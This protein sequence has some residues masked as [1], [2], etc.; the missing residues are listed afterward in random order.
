MMPSAWHAGRSM[1]CAARLRCSAADACAPPCPA[2]S[3]RQ[4]VGC[5]C[6]GR[7]GRGRLAN[8]R[9]GRAGAP[10]LAVARRGVH[11]PEELAEQPLVADLAR[12][13]R[14]LPRAPG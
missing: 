7:R 1:R 6:S 3:A 14:D 12:V 10:H 13:V 9:K 5:T 4:A 8:G 11:A 2:A